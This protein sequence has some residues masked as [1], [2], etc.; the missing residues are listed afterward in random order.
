MQRVNGATSLSFLWHSVQ[1]GFWCVR[2]HN[3]FFLWL[4]IYWAYWNFS[5]WVIWVSVILSLSQ[6]WLESFWFIWVFDSLLSTY[7]NLLLAM[8]VSRWPCS[9]GM[10]VR[11]LRMAPSCVV[12]GQ[13]ASQYGVGRAMWMCGVLSS[14]SL[15]VPAF[16][17]SS[18]NPFPVMPKC[19]RTL[20]MWILCGV[21]YIFLSM[22]AM[23]SLSGWW[24]CDVGYCIW[25]FIRYT[26]WDNFMVHGVNNPL[27][28]T[29][30]SSLQLSTQGQWPL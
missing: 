12:V 14:F 15:V 19:A 17:S 5:V 20:C 27:V 8:D 4:P 26:P 25:L 7:E 21:Q 13:L 29:E 30:C 6:K 2:G 1:L 28:S 18:A 9:F 3:I 10:N 22:A 16:A 24:C 23:S 11:K